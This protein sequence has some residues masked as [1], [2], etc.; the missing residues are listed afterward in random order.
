MKTTMVLQCGSDFWQYNMHV[1]YQCNILINPP[2]SVHKR[3]KSFLYALG[4]HSTIFTLQHNPWVY[5]TGQVFS[6]AH[7]GIVEYCASQNAT[8]G[9]VFYGK[10]CFAHYH[11]QTKLREGDVFT[12]VCDSVHRWGVHPPGKHP[13]SRDEH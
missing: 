6:F 1:K 10:N 7:G 2:F 3:E 5:R 13:L 4:L 8:P 12:P 11:P 9:K